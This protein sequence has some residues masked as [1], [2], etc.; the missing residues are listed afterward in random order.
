MGSNEHC[1]LAHCVLDLPGSFRFS[2]PT[3]SP[4][5]RG[6]LAG[7]RPQIFDFFLVLV[8]DIFLFLLASI[9]VCVWQSPFVQLFFF[10]SLLCF[11]SLG[12]QT[13]KFTPPVRCWQLY[14]SVA[15]RSAASRNGKVFSYVKKQRLCKNTTWTKR[16]LFA[17]ESKSIS[18]SAWYLP[19]S[20][21]TLSPSL[22]SQSSPRRPSALDQSKKKNVRKKPSSYLEFFLSGSNVLAGTRLA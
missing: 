17:V 5:G 20:S 9:L 13:I 8:F 19:Q 21:A 11:L 18:I 4:F 14:T 3:V 1:F 2:F 22:L 12:H 16:N 10:L 6:V 7:S 15:S